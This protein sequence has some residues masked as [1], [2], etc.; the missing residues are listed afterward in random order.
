[1]KRY[2]MR[3]TPNCFATTAVAANVKTALGQQFIDWMVSAEGQRGEHAH[4]FARRVEDAVG[5]L[6][7]EHAF[8]RGLLVPAQHRT[9]SVQDL[10]G[11]LIDAH[12]DFAVQG[13]G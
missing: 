10:D 8:A 9:C 3:A 7:D 6:H 11:V 1:M 13:G 5:V 12:S 2:G 4:G